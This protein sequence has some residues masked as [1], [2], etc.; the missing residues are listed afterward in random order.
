M[1]WGV[2]R[3]ELRKARDI[4]RCLRELSYELSEQRRRSWASAERGGVEPGRRTVAA[5]V[6]RGKFL[7]PR[8]VLLALHRERGELG[9]RAQ[10]VERE[11]ASRIRV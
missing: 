4:S 9:E 7:E 5:R 10:G 1:V 6:G 11:A 2:V 3:V 8:G